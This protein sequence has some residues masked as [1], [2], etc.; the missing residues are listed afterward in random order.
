MEKKKRRGQ[1]LR[2]EEKESRRPA[3]EQDYQLTVTTRLSRYDPAR[4]FWR[5]GTRPYIGRLKG[6]SL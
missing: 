6:V 3:C 2:K 5:A 1:R 4:R